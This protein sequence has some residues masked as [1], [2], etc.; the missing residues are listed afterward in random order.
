MKKT[1]PKAK[2]KKHAYNKR[3]RLLAE[4]PENVA[5]SQPNIFNRNQ[6]LASSQAYNLSL[7]I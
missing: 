7:E 3:R 6:M 4:L 5:R 2:F 1:Y